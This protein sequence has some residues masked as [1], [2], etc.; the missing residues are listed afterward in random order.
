MTDPAGRAPWARL[1]EELPTFDQRVYSSTSD[2]HGRIILTVEK[3][4]VLKL[5]AVVLAAGRDARREE[6]GSGTLAE[7]DRGVLERL[8]KKQEWAM[9]RPWEVN[10]DYWD[11]FH[12]GISE[13]IAVRS[14]GAVRPAP[15]TAE[16]ELARIRK[17]AKC[18]R[19]EDVI[20]HPRPLSE[21]QQLLRNFE[22]VA[23]LRIELDRLKA[24][25]APVSPAPKDDHE[26][27]KA[28]RRV[29]VVDGSRAQ[30]IRTLAREVAKTD[31]TALRRDRSVGPNHSGRSQDHR[32]AAVSPAV[33]G[34]IAQL[35]KL[36]EDWDDRAADWVEAAGEAS[37]TDTKESERMC[38][39][40]MGAFNHCINGVRHLRT[41]LEAALL[42]AG[43]DIDPPTST[44]TS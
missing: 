28:P 27:E 21:T 41:D 30:A 32:E 29:A 16:K 44:P 26:E 24:L 19:L 38:M 13:A 7:E 39:K 12:A 8:K 40:V 36:E 14:G 22:L 33:A 15:D 1:I 31:E 11:G 5:F 4:A 34:L 25:P 9:T 42:R 17:L 37:V 23:A 2:A 6:L 35:L 18:M 20:G 3:S 43:A 10:A